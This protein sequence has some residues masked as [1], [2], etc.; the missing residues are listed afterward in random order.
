VAYHKHHPTSKTIVELKEM[1]Q[2]GQFASGINRQSCEGIL[3]VTKRF[4]LQLGMDS[5]NIPSDS[6]IMN[7][8]LL[9]FLKCKNIA[10]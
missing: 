3:K 4:V 1:L 2:L 7:M 8:H 5:L 10:R 9:R 6:S